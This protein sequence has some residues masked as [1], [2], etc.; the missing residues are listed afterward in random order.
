MKE[1][2]TSP[3]A[4]LIGFISQDQVAFDLSFSDFNGVLSSQGSTEIS[5]TDIR[6][7]LK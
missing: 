3:E 1:T 4:K 5:G 2:Y 6:I 7:P